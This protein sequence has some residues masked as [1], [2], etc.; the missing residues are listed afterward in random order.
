MAIKEKSGKVLN[1]R[2]PENVHKEL[3]LEAVRRDKSVKDMV[4]DAIRSFI[5][6]DDDSLEHE[7]EPLTEDEKSAFEEGK[8]EVA[9]GETIKLEAYIS[10]V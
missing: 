7:E 8:R 6:L 3:K 1:I 5:Q 2:I 4:I 10:G 9:A